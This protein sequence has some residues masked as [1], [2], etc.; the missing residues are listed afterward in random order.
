MYTHSSPPGVIFIDTHTPKPRTY[1]PHHTTPRNDS[2]SAHK[3][4]CCGHH[5][6]PFFLPSLARP[7]GCVMA[8]QK[9]S[10]ADISFTHHDGGCL[11]AK[12]T[13]SILQTWF[14]DTMSHSECVCPASKPLHMRSAPSPALMFKRCAAVGHTSYPTLMCFSKRSRNFSR[15]SSFGSMASLKRKKLE[16]AVSSPHS[17]RSSRPS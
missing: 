4:C 3:L 14:F 9:A 8:P 1:I 6:I 16:T 11:H 2:S 10:G 12:R 15:E 7:I 17:F 13:S 5:V